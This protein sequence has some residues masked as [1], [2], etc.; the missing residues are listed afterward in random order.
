MATLATGA[1]APNFQLPTVQGGQFS[2]E[3][4]RKASAPVFAAFFKVSCPTCQYTFPYLERIYKA[5]PQDKVRFVGVSQNSKKDTEAFMRSYGVSFPMLLD[6]EGKYPASNAFKL[7]TVPSLFAISPAGE[8]EFA[9][10]G[11][12]K[13]DVEEL[14]RRVAAA[15]GVPPAQIFKPGEQ[16]AEAKAG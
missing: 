4:A 3:E 7:A 5:Y 12:N 10:I 8:I 15:A 11:W 1:S 16:V 2:L 9:S 13:G 14:N 6:P